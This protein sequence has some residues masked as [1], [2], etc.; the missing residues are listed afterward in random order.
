MSDK[1][2]VMIYWFFLVSAIIFEVAGTT[3]MKLSVGFTRFTPS[4]LIFVFYLASFAM[5]TL[6][7]KKFEVSVVYAVWSGIGTALIAI[8]GILYFREAVSAV[9]II[10]LMLI[11]IGVVGLH[12]GG[13][14][15]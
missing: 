3:A 5:L 10:S 9:K 1:E 11:I 6:T 13:A 4:V 14:Q 7:L 12:L 8:I 15:H 2:I